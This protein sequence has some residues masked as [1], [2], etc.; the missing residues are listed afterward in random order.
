MW[1]TYVFYGL[2]HVVCAG[3]PQGKVEHHDLVGGDERGDTHDE[4][5]V[6]GGGGGGA[7]RQG[8]IE[9]ITTIKPCLLVSYE[10]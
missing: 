3:T 6:P 7:L 1:S 9:E 2:R 5:D 8:V 4:D 10:P